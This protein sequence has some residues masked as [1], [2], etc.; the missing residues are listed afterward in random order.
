MCQS[1]LSIEWYESIDLV[2]E[3]KDYQENIL[4]NIGN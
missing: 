4:W 1:G 3:D 2:S